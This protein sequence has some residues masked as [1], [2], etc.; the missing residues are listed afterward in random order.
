VVNKDIGAVFPGDKAKTLGLIEPF[1]CSV[2]HSDI[3]LSLVA[4]SGGLPQ[5][6]PQS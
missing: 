6:N 5:K 2:C 3:L 4:V 1:H